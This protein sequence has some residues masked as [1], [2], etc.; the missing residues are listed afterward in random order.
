MTLSHISFR[1]KWAFAFR[2]LDSITEGSDDGPGEDRNSTGNIQHI[3]IVVIREQRL[4]PG[5]TNSRI[6][7]QIG[8]PSLIRISAVITGSSAI[9]SGE[10]RQACAF[11]KSV[12]CQV[13]PLLTPQLTSA[14]HTEMSQR[15]TLCSLTGAL[16]STQLMSGR[17]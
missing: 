10:S 6:P 1:I 2:S 14:A 7:G 5:I 11:H 8:M 15:K 9:Y 13:A 4:C 12:C 3:Y 17:R 16:A